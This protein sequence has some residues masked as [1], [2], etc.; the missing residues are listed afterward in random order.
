[1][2]RSWWLR[3]CNLLTPL[4]LVFFFFLSGYGLMTQL[5]LRTFVHLLRLQRPSGRAGSP[6]A[7]G[8]PEALPLL[9]CC[10][11]LLSLCGDGLR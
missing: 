5:R 7:L 1:M 2:R 3:V 11:T 6:D 10:G 9:L 8:A 4:A